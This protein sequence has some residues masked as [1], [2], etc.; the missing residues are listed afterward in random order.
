MVDRK[1]TVNQARA[2][3]SISPQL[4]SA[5]SLAQADF[6]NTISAVGNAAFAQSSHLIEMNKAFEAAAQAADNTAVYANSINKATIDYQNL[7][8]ERINQSVDEDGNPTFSTL[9]DDVAEIGNT[10]L[11][12]YLNNIDDPEVRAKF[13]QNFNAYTG[14][15]QIA[16]ISIAR[17]QQLSFISESVSQSVSELGTRAGASNEQDMLFFKNQAQ[18]ILDSAVM[19]GA[20][21]PEQRFNAE[22]SF[23]KEVATARI[24]NSI[25]EDSFATLDTLQNSL[26]EE[27]GLTE[28][29][30]LSLQN[31]AQTAVTR[32][33]R[34]QEALLKEQDNYIKEQ[35]RDF[36]RIISLGGQI[37]EESIDNISKIIVGSGREPEFI[38]IMN[39]AEATNE[40]TMNSPI[41]RTAILNGLFSNNELNLD[42]LELRDKLKSIDR[43]LNSKINDDVFSLAIEQGIVGNPEPFNPNSD[44][45]EQLSNRLSAI[46]FVEQHYNKR[47]S[48][49]TKEEING[50]QEAYLD[51]D[52]QTKASMLGEVI[53]GLGSSA[54]NFLEDL[55]INGSKQ[56]AAIG[57]L[58]LDGDSATATTVLKGQDVLDKQ[59]DIIPQDYREVEFG[60]IENKLP[61]YDLPEQQQD[62][63][64]M[65]KAIYAARSFESFDFSLDTNKNRLEDAI[66][67]VSNGGAISFNKSNIEPPIKDMTA[68]QFRRW[69]IDITPNDLER[70]GGWKGFDNQTAIRS[71]KSAQLVTQARGQ[72]IVFLRSG[73]GSM[74][75]VI[76]NDGDP[77]ILDYNKVEG[78]SRESIKGLKS[79]D[80]LNR[81]EQDYRERVFSQIK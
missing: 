2:Q 61:F 1:T 73:D 37:P 4:A 68:N 16:S 6:A 13:E 27:L 80:E 8:Q 3:A 51:G 54:L 50:F 28:L 14:N 63:R 72:Y 75:P 23:R 12:D 59:R 20:M 17:N 47:T 52:Y 65:A 69:I 43:E 33:I 46:G 5:A 64:E 36:D 21:T 41:S 55:S 57:S 58:I 76:N 35:L 40:F 79:V 19:S 11:N 31:E 53:S 7:F 67:Q 78:R 10:V 9:Q 71:L 22:D 38:K 30:R 32:E 39:E 56:A 42:Q 45:E 66:A 26:A 24:R 29:E 49:L 44:I 34:A 62:I 81:I 48:G 77:F 74:R 15:Q 18:A 25:N 60:V 70:L